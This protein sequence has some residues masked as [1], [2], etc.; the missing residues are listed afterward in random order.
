[1]SV[2]IQAAALNSANAAYN[3]QDKRALAVG[4]ALELIAARVSSSASVHLEQEIQNLSTYADQ[5]Q[6]AFNAS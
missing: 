5:I 6:A 3:A 1:M 4:I 2:T